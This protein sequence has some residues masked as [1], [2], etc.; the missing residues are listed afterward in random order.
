MR[1]LFL[2]ALAVAFLSGTVRAEDKVA[3]KIVLKSPDGKQTVDLEKL[4]KEGPVSVTGSDGSQGIG[5]AES[6][7]YPLRDL[8]TQ[9]KLATLGISDPSAPALLKEPSPSTSL[10]VQSGL[11]IL[12]VVL[13]ILIILCAIIHGVKWVIRDKKRPAATAKA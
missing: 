10:K 2:A 11:Y 9:S 5:F 6:V 12:L 7:G 1:H 8:I 3:P 13:L 4:Y